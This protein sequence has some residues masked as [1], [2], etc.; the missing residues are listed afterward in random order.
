[1][2]PS[3]EIVIPV[4]DEAKSIEKQI[5][6]L[7]KFL[8]M[9]N[10]YFDY[11]I[12]I[13]ENGSKDDTLFRAKSLAR[14][15]ARVE[16]LSVGERGVG[17]AIKSAWNNSNCNY[18][19]YM[20]LDFATDLKHLHQVEDYFLLG[21]DCVYGSRLLK[22]SKV[23]RR[24]LLRNTTSHILNMIIH[25]VFKT[26][27]SDVMCGFKFIK[28]DLAR[29]LMKGLAV[30]NGWFFCAE[31]AITSEVTGYSLAEIP[32]V[33]TDDGESKVKIMRLAIEYLRNIREL[34]KRLK[35]SKDQ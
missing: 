19:G 8:D 32:V 26:K 29:E 23:L 17:R 7:N 10:F 34:R 16:V 13:A 3:L 30:T 2:K 24:S 15:F 1:V 12:T 35:N 28:A 25:G 14:R 4:L 5:E 20:D 6:L 31:I 27:V 22:G 33:W 9:G 21:T 18:V 11:Q